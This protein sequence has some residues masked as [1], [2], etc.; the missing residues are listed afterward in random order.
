MI[1]L[2]NARQW[3]MLRVVFVGG[4]HGHG[5]EATGITAP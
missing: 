2:D 4:Q 5:K 1:L 3:S